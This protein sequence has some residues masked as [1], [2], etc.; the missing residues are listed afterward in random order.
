MIKDERAV[1]YLSVMANKFLKEHFDMKLN[2]PIVIS[3]RMTAALGR[4]TFQIGGGGLVRKPIKISLAGQLLD[5]YNKDEILDTLYHELVHYALFVKNEDFSDGQAN[6]E[7]TLKRLNIKSTGTTEYRGVLYVLP[8]TKCGLKNY[9]T[10]NLRES[11]RYYKVC[12]RC[13]SILDLKL[14]HK[15]NGTMSDVVKYYAELGLLD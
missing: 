3:N 5:N 9:S 8:C 15:E 4:F 10:K 14:K 13:D 2:I 1:L 11:K 6:F 12:K 7:N